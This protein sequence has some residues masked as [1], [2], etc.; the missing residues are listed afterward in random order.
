MSSLLTRDV[1]EQISDIPPNVT[2]VDFCRWMFPAVRGELSAEL[3]SFSFSRCRWSFWFVSN[4]CRPLLSARQLPAVL[5]A[6][7]SKYSSDAQRSTHTVH[8]PDEG[9]GIGIP[10][11]FEFCILQNMNFVLFKNRKNK[12]HKTKTNCQSQMPFDHRKDLD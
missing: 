6:K 8:V 3:V 9:I 1:K 12:K 11:I 10:N 4:G 7:A 5:S 2:D